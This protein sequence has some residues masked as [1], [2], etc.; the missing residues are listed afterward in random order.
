MSSLK[1]V[2]EEINSVRTNPKSYADKV[3]KYKEYFKGNIL[4]IPGEDAGVVTKEGVPAYEEAINFLNEA[5]NLEPFIPSKGLTKIASEYQ[6][7]IEKVGMDKSDTIEIDPI[8]DKYGKYTAE[9]NQMLECGGTTPEQVVMHLLVC[10]GD[11]T[12]EYRK[13]LMNPNLKKIG[14]AS[15]KNDIYRKSTVIIVAND[16][17]NKDNSD[18]AENFEEN[19]LAETE[20]V[21]ENNV[22][23]ET[24]SDSNIP[25]PTLSDVINPDYKQKNEE[26][27]K[28][29]K[30]EEERKKKEEE[31]RLKKEEEERKKKE[32]EERL[33]QEEEERLKIE[34]E[35]K[36]KKEEEEKKKKEEEEKKKKE[37]E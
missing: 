37:E 19:I 32:E 3:N 26:E 36:K 30:E 1:E 7:E 35:E 22:L 24:N 18:D 34:E 17:K 16:F 12:R 10:D 13:I 2:L 6:N 25:L 27:E 15:G 5:Q 11:S 21:E 9:L 29:K 33:K 8:I 28:K 20:N 31:E 4:Y 14:I 23:A